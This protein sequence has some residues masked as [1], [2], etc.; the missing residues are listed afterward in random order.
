MKFFHA[1]NGSAPLYNQPLV[2]KPNQ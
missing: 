2:S 1:F